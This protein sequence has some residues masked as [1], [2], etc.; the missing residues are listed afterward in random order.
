M[1]SV[2]K[3][4]KE[5]FPFSDDAIINI[6][7][8]EEIEK[9]LL[10]ELHEELPKSLLPK[11]SGIVNP[12]IYGIQT[13]SDFVNGRQRVVL[14]LLIKGL[15]DEIQRLNK[16]QNYNTSRYVISILTSYIDQLVD[17]NCRFSMW[18]PQNEQVGRSFCGPGIS[19]LWD[20]I[21]TDPVLNGPA[22][23]WS[24]LNRI[25]AGT[26]SII[27]FQNK[28]HV[29][30]GHAQALNFP[31]E[32]FD[33]IVTDP[34]YYDNI[35]YTILADFFYVWKRLV[36]KNIDADL[37]DTEI[38]N[39]SKELVASKFRSGTAKKAHEEYCEQL[40]LALHE[41][42]RVLKP[43]GIFSFLYSHSSLNG[44]EAVL[45]AFRAT[46]FRITSVQ[47]LSIERRQRPRA[48]TSQAVNTCITFIAH[49]DETKKKSESIEKQKEK[50]RQ[51]YGDFA[52][53]LISVGW[54]EKDVA[55]AVFANGVGMLANLKEIDEDFS[56]IDVLR[57][58]ESVVKE[59]FP[60]FKLTNRKSL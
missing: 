37:F 50:I 52:S 42:E 22:N 33:A 17:W 9:S 55:L 41:A 47:P 31:N 32:F 12:A 46:N 21:E 5:F 16:E 39:D 4:G 11:W 2:G 15:K 36:L 40:T 54:D 35:F 19:M 3:N 25:V 45:R 44:W 14:L 28:V 13:H 8:I 59:R 30:H 1:V 49:K 48:M 23:L 58:L 10:L 34:P 51:N 26:K 27:Q 60:L 29:L 53:R 43:D 56:D 24:K 6:E 20:Y 18:I 38:T 7:K 57:E